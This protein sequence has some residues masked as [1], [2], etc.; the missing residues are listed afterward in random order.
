MRALQRINDSLRESLGEAED[1][2]RD[3]L[4][5]LGDA[6]TEGLTAD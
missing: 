3:A 6:F 5:L 4:D 2:V 1:D